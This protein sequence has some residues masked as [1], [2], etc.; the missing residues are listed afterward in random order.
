MVWPVTCLFIYQPMYSPE[1]LE[2][3]GDLLI[4]FDGLFN[5]FCSMGSGQAATTMNDMYPI[6]QQG[7]F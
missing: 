1:F 2:N 6:N 3:P 7:Q 5:V 4:N